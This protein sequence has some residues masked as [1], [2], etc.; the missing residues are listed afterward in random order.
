M[1]VNRETILRRHDTSGH[2]KLED[3]VWTTKTCSNFNSPYNYI[4][5]ICFEISLLTFIPALY[6]NTGCSI[7]LGVNT[8]Y[9]NNH[10]VPISMVMQL[11]ISG[12]ICIIVT[13]CGNKTDNCPWQLMDSLLME[14]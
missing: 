2:R 5:H 10:D 7:G 1:A 13:L 14:V 4:K 11:Q 12:N 8:C 6:T 3:F 9:Q